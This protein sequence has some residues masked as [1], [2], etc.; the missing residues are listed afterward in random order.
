MFTLQLSF[1]NF[2]IERGLF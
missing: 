2:Y 1:A